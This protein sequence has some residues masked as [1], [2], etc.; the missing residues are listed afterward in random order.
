MAYESLASE[1]NDGVT[2]HNDDALYVGIDTLK[3]ARDNIKGW[4]LYSFSSE[5]FVVSAVATYVPLL[6]EQFARINGVQLDDH[7]APCSTSSSDKCV[8]GLFNN[9]VF[10][11]SSSFALYVFSLSVLFQ[12]VV[13]ISVSGMVD[14][15]K[16]ISFRKNVLVTFGMVGAFATV[17]IS[18]LNETQYYSLVVYYIVANSCYGVINVVG[19]SLLPL[20]VDDLVRLQP[21][22]T[23][24]AA[25]ELS[26][27]TDD[28]DGLT[29]VIS[30]R[31]ASIG[32]SAALVVQLMSILLVRL[33]P[34]KQDIQYAV[35][36]VGLWWAVW[37][38]PMYWLLSDSIIPDQQSNQ[39]IANGRYYDI[40]GS[41]FTFVNLSSLKYGW[42]LL[43][44]AL[45]HATLLRDVVIF[46][47]G[48]FILSDS[49]TTIN[50]TAIIFA[51]TELHMST[52]NLISLSIITMISAMVGA[53]AIPQIVSTSLHVPPQRTILLII[54]W[55]SIIP[56]YGML[57]FIFQ[58]FGLKHQFEMF[59]LG[60]WYGISMGSV[61]AVSRSLFTII[62]PKGRESTFFSLFSITDKGSSIVGPFIIGIVTDKTHNIRY[63]F[64][65]L[66]IL[67]VFSLPIFKM[68][69]VERGK[70]EAE[71]ISK[72]HVNID[73]IQD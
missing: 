51:K 58:S 21:D 35:F 8:L 69:N 54:C 32:Y 66:F 57:G 36:F 70:R 53:F 1:P 11:D 25:E 61:A 34:S 71:E 49:L 37:Q 40:D 52:I 20:F 24:P 28:K 63:S 5:P 19:N 7:N 31:G 48:W 10:V 38:F 73:P 46:L 44:E 23:V 4:Y 13:V 42:K 56:L 45:K 16:T 65:I 47:I 39:A 59:I 15:W 17:L 33:S 62:I 14:R 72:L 3:A 50:S 18:L 22:H 43:G 41:I 6:L 12:T 67:L 55:A 60:V 68:L 64:F 2:D 29:T 27:D 30:G 9:R 26:L